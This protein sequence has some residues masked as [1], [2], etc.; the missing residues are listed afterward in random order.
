MRVAIVWGV[1]AAFFVSPTVSRFH[2]SRF[3]CVGPVHS[4]CLARLRRSSVRAV[5]LGPP[6]PPP[7]PLAGRTVVSFSFPYATSARAAA[8]AAAGVSAFFFF[9]VL[10]SLINASRPASKPAE[11]SWRLLS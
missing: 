3:T 8:A 10:C 6:P 4:A 2:I 11:S 1:R 5:S 7:V 9:L